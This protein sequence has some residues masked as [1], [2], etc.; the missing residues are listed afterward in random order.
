MTHSPLEKARDEAKIALDRYGKSAPYV[1]ALSRLAALLAEQE[2]LKEAEEVYREAISASDTAV[3]NYGPTAV[4]YQNLGG[5]T[6]TQ[7]RFNEARDLFL[8]ALSV[9]VSYYGKDSEQA[10]FIG[11]KLSGLEYDA[12]NLGT[13]CDWLE[14][15]RRPDDRIRD[16]CGVKADELWGECIAEISLIRE[17]RSKVRKSFKQRA[18]LIDEEK[19]RAIAVSV[20]ADHLEVFAG[21]PL[22][23]S[24]YLPCD[25]ADCWFVRVPDQVM[26][27]GASRF[28]IVSK[29]TGE[30]LGDQRLGE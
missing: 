1:A 29:K 24:A 22:G 30:I 19:A 25:P 17:R 12:E 20:I 14:T 13:A 21:P 18:E 9:S 11:L 15:I 23:A 26:M 27:L 4:L 10:R 8:K 28:I 7:R 16:E 5:I 2:R 6:L 3:P